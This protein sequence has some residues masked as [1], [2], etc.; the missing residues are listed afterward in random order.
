MFWR[1]KS[2]DKWIQ[3]GDRNTNF[4]HLTTLVRRRR[5][6]IEG[7]FNSDGSWF[8]DASSMKNIVVEFFPNLFSVQEVVDNRFVCIWPFPEIDQ[9]HVD[10]ICKPIS[11][12]NVKS[13]LFSIGGLKAP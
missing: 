8:S 5:N 11:L 3:D 6:K 2:R 12:L 10:E 13:S 1:Q 4:F 7:L 9:V